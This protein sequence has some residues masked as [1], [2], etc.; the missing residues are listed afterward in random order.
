MRIPPITERPHKDNPVIGRAHQPSYSIYGCQK[1]KCRG[2]WKIRGLSPQD[3]GATQ[4]P[5]AVTGVSRR[6]QTRSSDYS[7][8]YRGETPRLRCRNDGSR[9]SASSRAARDGRY[10]SHNCVSTAWMAAFRR[11]LTCATALGVMWKGAATFSRGWP[12]TT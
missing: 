5:T 10:N 3:E 12:S 4:I 6:R 7:H 11:R 9:R 8:L 2:L 1:P